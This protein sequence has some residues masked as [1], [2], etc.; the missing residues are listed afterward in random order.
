[1]GRLESQ[2]LGNKSVKRVVLWCGHKGA[3]TV[4]RSTDCLIIN[5]VFQLYMIVDE[6]MYIHSVLCN[7]QNESG[8]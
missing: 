4:V 2:C 6:R 3:V 1:M 7:I 8:F 5:T